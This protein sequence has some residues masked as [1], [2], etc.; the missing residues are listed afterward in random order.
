[1]LVF[2]AGATEQWLEPDLLPRVE[3]HVAPFLLLWTLCSQSQWAMTGVAGD[4]TSHPTHLIMKTLLSWVTLWWAFTWNTN[5]LKFF[6]PL[7]S[8]VHIPLLQISLSSIFPIMFLL[9][10]WPSSQNIGLRQCIHI[11]SYLWPFSPSKENEQPDALLHFPSPPPNSGR[12]S[13]HYCPSGVSQKGTVLC[14]CLFVGG[15]CIFYSTI[16][17]SASAF[18]SSVN[19]SKV[20]L[21][22]VGC[23][24]WRENVM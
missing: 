23:A 17:K 14:S 19:W 20:I 22:E 4:R 9:S 6:C 11:D 2:V 1:M 3:V 15:V 21:Y 16:C 7:K 24:A 12:I 13:L 8:S 18:S 5:I 10:P